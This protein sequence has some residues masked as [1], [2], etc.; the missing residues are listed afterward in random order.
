METI[1]LYLPNLAKIF[2]LT[3][4]SFV[5][6]LIWTPIFTDFLYRNNLGKRIRKTGIDEKNGYA[7]INTAYDMQQHHA[8]CL[9]R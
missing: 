1:Q 5:I 6:A 8:L 9:H 7:F 4:L 3:T 2:W